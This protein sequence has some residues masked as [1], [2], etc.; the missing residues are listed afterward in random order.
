MCCKDCIESLCDDCGW[1]FCDKCAG[2]K[3]KCG[4]YGECTK[5]GAN[6]TYWEDGSNCTICNTWLCSACSEQV[7][8]NIKESCEECYEKYFG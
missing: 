1:L 6:V 3:Y 7:T 5:C 4:C 2:G 8:E